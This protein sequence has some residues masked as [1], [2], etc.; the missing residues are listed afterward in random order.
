LYTTAFSVQVK[1]TM[2]GKPWTNFSHQ[3]AQSV[4]EFG[5]WTHHQSHYNSNQDVSTWYIHAFWMFLLWQ[6]LFGFHLTLCVTFTR[7]GLHKYIELTELGGSR[8]RG[9][10]SKCYGEERTAV[11]FGANII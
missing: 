3:L 8:V 5:E 2:V 7:T 6:L 10:E 1:F 11:I 4:D 9:K